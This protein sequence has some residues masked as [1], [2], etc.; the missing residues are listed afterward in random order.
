[1]SSGHR[2]LLEHS[3]D[4]ASEVPLETA[5]RLAHALAFA[6]VAPFLLTRFF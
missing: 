5:H 1:V 2:R 4:V 3:E 6:E